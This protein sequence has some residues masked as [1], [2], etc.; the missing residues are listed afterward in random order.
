MVEYRQGNPRDQMVLYPQ[1]IDEL[2]GDE[3]IVRIIDAYVDALNMHELGFKMNENITGAPAYRPQLKLKI[4][5]YGYFN[6]IRSS[7]RLERECARNIELIWLTEG[8]VLDFKTIA[9]FRRDNPKALKAVFKDFVKMCARLELV[10]LNTV[11]IDGTKMRG[12]NSGNEIYRREQIEKVEQD[13]QEKIDGYLKALDELDE[14]ERTNGISENPEKIQEF[15]KRL[16]KQQHRKD[17]VAGI[18]KLFADYP[19]VKSYFA[20]D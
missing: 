10:S 5:V 7:R 9:D 17:K 18:K 20:T 8:L 16:K 2:V 14:Q 4:Y 3:D 15:L 6:G 11:A 1:F 12:Q 13:I 19:D